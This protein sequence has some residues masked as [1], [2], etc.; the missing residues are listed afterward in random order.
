MKIMNKLQNKLKKANK[1]NKGFSL[2]ELI[3]VIAI[4][5][6]LVGI[7]G[8]QVIPY[9]NK[10]K[11]EKDRQLLSSYATAAVS[12]YT[13]EAGEIAAAPASLDLYTGTHT[14]GSDDEKLAKKIKELTYSGWPDVKD[15]FKSS[16]AKGATDVTIKYDTSK[17]TVTV[18]LKDA[19]T[20]DKLDVTAD[21]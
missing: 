3:I 18:T 11:L 15:K 7:V 13:M 2:V 4:M 10:S 8:T 19:A 5:A 12:A 20:P 9:L 6:I 14:A 17:H 1:D 16:E 21:L